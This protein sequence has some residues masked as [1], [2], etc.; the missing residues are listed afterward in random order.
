MNQNPFVNLRTKKDLRWLSPNNFVDRVLT[1]EEITKI[2]KLC[3]ALWIHLGKPTDPHAELTSGKH[4]NGFV[5][6]LKALVYPNLRRIFAHQLVRVLDQH[7][8][9]DCGDHITKGLFNWV[10][11]SDHAGAALAL[12]V[13]EELDVMS[14]FT[15][16]EQ[17]AGSKRQIWNRH[18]IEPGQIVLQVEE[19]VTTSLTLS[20]VRA[21]IRE[22]TS[23]TDFS[24]GPYAL[25][26]VDRSDPKAR[27]TEIEGTEI[28]HLVRYEIDTW[29]PADCPLCKSGSLALKPKA[30]WKELTS[31]S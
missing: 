13:G 26:L 28:L 21:G 25:T 4:S 18:T 27:V 30:N 5:N 8:L 3:D 2:L 14:T 9:D 7:Y 11:G 23:H 20:A 10:V 6:V 29:E 24:F 17:V 19:L 1:H 22:G 12:A 15:E 16:K 31:V